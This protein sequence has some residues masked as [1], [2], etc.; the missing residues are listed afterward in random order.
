M[1][2]KLLHRTNYFLTQNM[3]PIYK[4]FKYIPANFFIWAV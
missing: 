3:K 2:V 1:K 4:I